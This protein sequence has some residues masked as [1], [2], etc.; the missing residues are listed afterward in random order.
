MAGATRANDIGISFTD[1]DPEG[2]ADIDVDVGV[3]K[4]IDTH[5]TS[6]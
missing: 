3:G 1:I 6:T 2:D 4:D 5:V